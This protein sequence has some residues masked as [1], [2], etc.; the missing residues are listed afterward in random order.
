MLT[1]TE[2]NNAIETFKSANVLATVL[3]IQAKHFG[4]KDSMKCH[5]DALNKFNN[6][7]FI[8]EK[9]D[10]CECVN[11]DEIICEIENISI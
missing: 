3:Y 9:Y 5:K 6:Y 1:T 7:K 10:G 2:I 11:I 8:L 4:F